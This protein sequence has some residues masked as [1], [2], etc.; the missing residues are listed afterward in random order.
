MQSI[1]SYNIIMTLHAWCSVTVACTTI[2][3]TVLCS[4]IEILLPKSDR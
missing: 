4:F 1:A 2:N 3:I